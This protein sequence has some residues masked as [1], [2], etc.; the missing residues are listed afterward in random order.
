M[1]LLRIIMGTWL[2][3]SLASI[4]IGYFWVGGIE[5]KFD[6]KLKYAKAKSR[7]INAYMFFTVRE[8]SRLPTDY[9]DA[10]RRAYRFILSGYIA[11]FL[12]CV[13]LILLKFVITR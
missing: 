8:L 10:L 5:A 1:S 3:V 12:A 13:C 2:F 6:P 11:L 4:F 9:A 7:A